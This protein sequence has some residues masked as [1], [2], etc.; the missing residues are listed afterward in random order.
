MICHRDRAASS[1]DD[2]FHRSEPW[3][4]FPGEPDVASGPKACGARGRI[5]PYARNLVREAADKFLRILPEGLVERYRFI[6]LLH[7]QSCLSRKNSVVGGR[8][9][10]RV[11]TH[12]IWL[13][14]WLGILRY[15]RVCGLCQLGFGRGWIRC[16]GV[17]VTTRKKTCER[18]GQCPVNQPSSHAS[19]LIA[20]TPLS[21]TAT[22]AATAQVGCQLLLIGNIPLVGISTPRNICLQTD[23]TYGLSLLPGNSTRAYSF[24]RPGG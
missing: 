23:E 12:H 1:E 22:Q 18:N 8:C 5:R 3:R 10:T 11:L 4:Y 14:I 19:R 7:W 21:I 20:N 15:C 16:V 2:V 13:N 17:P 9:G 6:N 24:F